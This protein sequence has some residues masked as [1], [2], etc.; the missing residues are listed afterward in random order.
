MVDALITWATNAAERQLS[1]SANAYFVPIRAGRVT[2]KPPFN[3][4]TSWEL[5]LLNEGIVYSRTSATKIIDIAG[6]YCQVMNQC[7]SR[8]LF[9]Y[10]M[11][12]MR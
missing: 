5:K 9:V 1:I 11:F 6:Y 12:M 8:N 7:N 2:P 4:E 10:W 3:F